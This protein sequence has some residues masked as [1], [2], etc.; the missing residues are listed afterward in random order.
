[1]EIIVV[2]DDHDHCEQIEGTKLLNNNDVGV[3]AAWN[4]GVQAATHGRIL[5]MNNDIRVMGEY[6]H[7][8]CGSGITGM[9]LRTER[10]TN[11]CPL[12]EVLEGWCFSFDKSLWETLGGFDEKMKMYF[13]DTDFQCRAVIDHSEL[14]SVVDAPLIHLQHKTAHDPKIVEPIERIERWRKDRWA[15]SNKWGK[16]ARLAE[17]ST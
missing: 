14:L 9:K 7:L 4:T 11:R 15:F 5:L 3:T 17:L 16:R 13:S 12:G 10:S 8:F 6:V 2:N 1:M